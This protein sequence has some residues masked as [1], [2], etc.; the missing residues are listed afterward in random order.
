MNRTD[1]H[2]FTHWPDDLHEFIQQFAA[3]RIIGGMKGTYFPNNGKWLLRG[4]YLLTKVTDTIL[5]DLF[6]GPELLGKGFQIA[7]EKTYWHASFMP[8]VAAYLVGILGKRQFLPEILDLFGKATSGRYQTGSLIALHLL[9]GEETEAA[10]AELAQQTQYRE[11]GRLALEL[12]RSNQLLDHLKANGRKQILTGARFA[13]KL[14]GGIEF[15]TTKELQQ[16]L[17]R[18]LMI[19]TPP[20]MAMG[21]HLNYVIPKS[22][23]VGESEWKQH[24]LDQPSILVPHRYRMESL[25]QLPQL[26]EEPRNIDWRFTQAVLDYLRLGGGRMMLGKVVGTASNT[27]F[28]QDL[29]GGI[30]ADWQYHLPTEVIQVVYE[31]LLKLLPPSD[32]LY[33]AYAYALL[34]RGNE[35][36]LQA[37]RLIERAQKLGEEFRWVREDYQGIF[38]VAPAY[39]L[40]KGEEFGET[41]GTMAMGGDFW[42]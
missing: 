16:K 20:S 14:I 6:H 38:P 42:G 10:I 9:R 2:S 12:L 17:T 1:Q 15:S 4:R 41:K 13:H 33:E 25:N 19:S 30:E 39:I 11:S 7:F 35:N 22:F 21:R 37:K 34:W 8:E 3:K 26:V 28:P 27:P 24:Q 32:Y 23:A 31:R 5:M 18:L 40:G 36:D 29:I